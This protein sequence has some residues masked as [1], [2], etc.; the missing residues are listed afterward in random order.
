[1][2]VD[3][4]EE[5]AGDAI[6]S[7]DLTD[8]KRIGAKDPCSVVVMDTLD[9]KMEDDV[10]QISMDAQDEAAYAND[11]AVSDATEKHKIDLMD[12]NK[13]RGVENASNILR[14]TDEDASAVREREGNTHCGGRSPHRFFVP[15]TIKKCLLYC[16]KSSLFFFLAT[17]VVL[18]N[19]RLIPSLINLSLNPTTITTILFTLYSCT[20]M[21]LYIVHYFGFGPKHRKLVSAVRSYEARFGFLCSLPQMNK[22]LKSYCVN[23]LVSSSL[24]S[25]A[26]PLIAYFLF[27]DQY[28]AYL[29][30]FGDKHGWQFVLVSAGFCV[31]SALGNLIWSQFLL[32]L[33]AMTWVL[34]KE[35]DQLTK[36]VQ[37]TLRNKQCEQRLSEKRLKNERGQK[38][39]QN[40][41]HVSQ[42]QGLPDLDSRDLSD[43]GISLEN[44]TMPSVERGLLHRPH[45][46][47]VQQCWQHTNDSNSSENTS[48]LSSFRKKNER[49][50]VLKRR[51]NHNGDK[52]RGVTTQGQS[53][54]HLTSSKRSLQHRA[55]DAVHTNR[56]C[57]CT[58]SIGK[59]PF[60]K[61]G[62][63]DCNSTERIGKH[64]HPYREQANGDCN[65]TE[66]IVKHPFREQGNN[67]DCNSTERIVKHP[68]REQANGDCNS[69]ERIGQHPFREQANGDCTSTERTIK[70][71]FREQGNDDCGDSKTSESSISSSVRT[72]KNIEDAEGGASAS[73]EATTSIE[74]TTSMEEEFDAA[75]D[76]H[77]AL[78]EM[79]SLTHSCFVHLIPIMFGMCIPQVCFVV[80]CLASG[81][82]P[83]SDLSKAAGLVTTCLVCLAVYTYIGLAIHEAVSILIVVVVVVVVFIVIVIIGVVVVVLNIIN[84]VII[85]LV[86]VV[87]I[88][89]VIII[90]VIVVVIIIII[91]SNIISIIVI[92]MLLVCFP[93]EDIKRRYNEN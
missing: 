45:P 84:I 23:F 7:G 33:G 13:R 4:P 65:S 77:E 8:S 41:A 31:Y 34:K 82:L 85:I 78:C 42:H 79:V 55:E 51:R 58:E 93:I 56:A 12:E 43:E 67:G 2:V 72:L 92:I 44:L 59:H 64:Q 20:G 63:G 75:R 15:N 26:T 36:N 89:I 39:I 10:L 19:V 53:T 16:Y 32:A 52:E 91:S 61:Q 5:H 83:V 30:P 73:M 46:N 38:L 21:V 86:V 68:Y 74:A 24:L 25:A 17:I 47:S 40:N 6:Q 80:W 1:V 69:T 90:V 70:H 35:F 57:A 48:S 88:N 76:R 54:D 50:N 87:L 81:S 3:I 60:R 37:E 49:K 11:D 27:P 71:P 14:G 22:K 29:V 18:G 62:N 28:R 66:R 9:E